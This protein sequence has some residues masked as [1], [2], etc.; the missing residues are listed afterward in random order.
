[1][2]ELIVI[3]YPDPAE[4]ERVI[5][6]I[7]RLQSEHLVQLDDYTYVTRDLDGTVNLHV[8]LNRPALG[9]ARGAC[10]APSLAGSSAHRGLELD[11]GR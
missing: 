8:R 1:M 2:G 7:E 4:A 6:T 11:S 9:V 10:G 5:Q 3:T